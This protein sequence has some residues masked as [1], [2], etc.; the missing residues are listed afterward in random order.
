MCHIRK[1]KIVIVRVG[2]RK[3]DAY[4]LSVS[5]LSRVGDGVEPLFRPSNSKTRNSYSAH[6]WNQ[7]NDLVN[8]IVRWRFAKCIAFKN[9]YILQEKGWCTVFFILDNFRSSIEGAERC[10]CVILWSGFKWYSLKILFGV[11]M[12]KTN[13]FYVVVKTLSFCC[14]IVAISFTTKTN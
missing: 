13:F 14:E 8:S 2:Q 11:Q 4:L 6:K 1:K 7:G 10:G 3:G 9:F 5:R 12:W